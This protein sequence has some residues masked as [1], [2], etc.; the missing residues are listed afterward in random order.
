MK[1]DRCWAEISALCLSKAQEALEKETVPTAETVET[2]KQ[3]IGIAIAIDDLNLR[4]AEQNR[5]Y[6]A[7][8]SGRS[9]GPLSAKN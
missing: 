5:F 8:H 1:D 7:G 9:S 2:V 6:A 3:L 4:W